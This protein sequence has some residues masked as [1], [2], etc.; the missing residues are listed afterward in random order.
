MPGLRE[1]RSFT[2][3]FRGLMFERERAKCFMFFPSCR[4][5]HTLF[6]RVKIDVLFVDDS[7]RILAIHRH[8]KPWRMV[9]GPAAATG[10]LEL[11]AGAA[12][13]YGGTVGD[14]LE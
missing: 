6:M 9:F 2:D 14:R 11:P 8:V 5:I 12:D 1:A 7:S 10:T 3:R 13:E 4:A